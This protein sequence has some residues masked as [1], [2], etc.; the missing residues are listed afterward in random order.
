ML[1]VPDDVP[2]EDC[3]LTCYPS[4]RQIYDG[5]FVYVRTEDGLEG[6]IPL[7]SLEHD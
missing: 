5:W 3:G 2:E 6:W 1:A 7:D 4:A